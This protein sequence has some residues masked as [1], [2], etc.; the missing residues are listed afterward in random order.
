MADIVYRSAVF[1]LCFQCL[2]LLIISL[3]YLSPKLRTDSEAVLRTIVTLEVSSQGAEL[4]WYTLVVFVYRKIATW[5]RYI[6]WVF[7]TPLMLMSLALFFN[8]RARAP[9][10]DISSTFQWWGMLV[11]NMLMLVGGF[12]VETQRVNAW[13]GLLFGSVSFVISFFFLG[14]FVDRSDVL[15]FVLFGINYT[16]WA[17]YGVAACLSYVGKNVAYNNLDIVSKNIFGLFLLMYVLFK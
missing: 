12:L 1:S 13:Q 3:S 7:S 11:F 4:L 17:L 5:T 9:V 16:I 14:T 2:T 15:S 8:H 10:E 6:D